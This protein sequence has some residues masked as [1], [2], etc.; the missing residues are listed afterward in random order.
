[1]FSLC[2]ATASSTNKPFWIFFICLLVVSCASGGLSLT[3]PTMKI[4]FLAVL[5]AV[6][7]PVAAEIY[8]KEQFNDEVRRTGTVIAVERTHD[9]GLG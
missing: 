9:C 8:F 7:T 6:A 1:M 2:V 3:L 4:S 5:A